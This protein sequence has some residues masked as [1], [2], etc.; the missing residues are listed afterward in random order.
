MADKAEFLQAI[1]EAILDADSL[2]RFINGDDTQDVLTRLSKRYPTLQKALK[3]LFENVGIAGRFKTLAELQASSLADGAYAL[4][5]DDADGNNGI[6]IKDSGAWLKSKYSVE[7][8]SLRV[9]LKSLA[10]TSTGSVWDSVDLQSVIYNNGVIASSDP[11]T[12]IPHVVSGLIGRK[13]IKID[14]S[15]AKRAAFV[16][17]NE[18]M[19]SIWQWVITDAK[20]NRLATIT[21]HSGSI[22]DMPEGA[23]YAWRTFSTENTQGNNNLKIYLQSKSIP[24]FNL[25]DFYNELNF[26]SRVEV[27]DFDVSSN[28]F[29]GGIDSDSPVGGKIKLLLSEDR[30]H[31]KIDISGFNRVVASD[32]INLTPW[33]WLFTDANDVVIASDNLY[34]DIDIKIPDGAKYLY[35]S[36]SSPFNVDK[37]IKVKLYKSSIAEKIISAIDNVPEQNNLVS[38]SSHLFTD[39]IMWQRLQGAFD[40]GDTIKISDFSGATQHQ[41]IDNALD[42]IRLR[43]WGVLD[44]ESGTWLRDSAVVLPSNTWLYLNDATIKL[45]DGVFDN[46]IRVEGVT[47][48]SDPYAMST[49]VESK[50]IRVFGKVGGKATL[51]GPDIPKTAPHP[52]NGGNAVPWVGDFYG[53]R[54]IGVYFI[55]TKNYELDNFALVQATCWSISNEHGCDNFKIHDIRLDNNVKNGDG[56]DLRIGCKNA[57]VYNITGITGDDTV[58]LSALPK[59]EQR[60]YPESTYIY[61]MQLGGYIDAGHGVNIE[62]VAIYNIKAEGDHNGVRLLASGGGKLKNISVDNVEDAGNG[63]RYSALL[64]SSGYGI[65]AVMGDM[66]N[67]TVNGITSNNS[68]QALKLA[69]KIKDSAFNNIV[70]RNSSKTLVDD[71]STKDNVKI[72]NASKG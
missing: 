55:N 10:E 25:V 16:D 12:K 31:L 28:V 51:S 61:P 19:V 62:N 3:E 34:G 60:T 47:V 67:I 66:S 44:M 68:G 17:V 24:D 29:N 57:E 71:T 32:T 22:I 39:D 53:W 64:V 43:G 11:N 70:Q 5:A 27:Q 35:K 58:A 23:V 2:E 42:F 37:D 38:N 8:M 1:N 63:W 52:V 14:V 65:E 18:K 69:G 4:V 54:T 33:R 49:A 48:P 59:P 7:A 15:N 6:Y 72:T 30:S 9:M 41:K 45:K 56:V 36:H 40:N 13:Y 26:F 46:I 21:A 20:K 50:N